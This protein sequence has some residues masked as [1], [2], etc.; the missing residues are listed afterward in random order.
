MY[1]VNCL[2]EEK[3]NKPRNKQNYIP[4]SGFNTAIF[5]RRDFNL[6]KFSNANLSFFFIIP[7]QVLLNSS[8]VADFPVFS[9]LLPENTIDIYKN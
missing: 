3:I 6:T 7:A 1:S 4:F 9:R 8:Y 5:H 2:A